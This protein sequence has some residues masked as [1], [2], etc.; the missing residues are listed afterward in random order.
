M[1]LSAD[2]IG[3]LHLDVVHHRRKVVGGP[4]VAA[5]QDRIAD[6]RRV[7]FHATSDP[8]LETDFAFRHPETADGLLPGRLTRL[9]LLPGNRS[10]SPRIE[11]HPSCLSVGLTIRFEPLGAAEAIV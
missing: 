8:I 10:A 7:D 2:Y 1:I 11:G 9:R 4:P 5:E 6:Q 3:D